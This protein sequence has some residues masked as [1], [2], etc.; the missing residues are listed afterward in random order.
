[1]TLKKL[2]ELPDLDSA[3]KGA[4]AQIEPAGCLNTGHHTDRG[5]RHAVT[6]TGVV[7]LR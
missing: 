6:Q 5:G 2:D 3:L 7:S 4:D 1:M